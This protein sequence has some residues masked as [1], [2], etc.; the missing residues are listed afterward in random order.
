M[1]NML[2]RGLQQLMADELAVSISHDDQTGT[3][4]QQLQRDAMWRDRRVQDNQRELTHIMKAA[5]TGEKEAVPQDT[6]QI[7]E[8]N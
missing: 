4:I 2:R 5:A 1:V 3:C 8:E 6:K 7:L